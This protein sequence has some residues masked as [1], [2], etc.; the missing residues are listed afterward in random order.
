MRSPREETNTNTESESLNKEANESESKIATRDSERDTKTYIDS[1]R[2]NG[3]ERTIES[4]AYKKVANKTR[5]IATTLP[6]EFRIVRRIPSD[7]LVNLPILPTHPPEFEPGERYT[8]ERMEAMPVNKDGFLWPEEVKL[9]HYLIREHK[10]AFAWNENEKGKFSD[11]YFDPVV[12]PTVEHVPWVLRNIPIPPGIY[13]RVVEVIKHKIRTG[14]FESSNSSYRSRWFC[15][16][17]KDGKSLR[18]VHDLQPLNAVTIRDSALIPMVEQYAESFGGRGCYAMFDLFVGFDQRAL[19]IK[20]RDLTTFQ[21]P[22]GTFRMTSIPMGYT[23]SVQIQQG[24]I[25]FI[26]QEEIPH[27]T[28]P[29]IDDIP[30]KGPPTRYTDESGNFET[31]P[32][33]RGIRRFIWEHLQNV[34]RVIQRI[35]HAGGTFSG[36]KSFICVESTIIVGHRCTYEGRIPDESR[37]QKIMDWPICRNLT[38]VRG[39]LG[40]LGTIR[41]FIKNFAMH[42]RP[43]V[44][45]TRKNIEFEFGGEQLLAMEKMKFLTQE[46]PAIRTIDY[47]SENEVI[48]SVDSSWMAVGFILSQ[49]GDNGKRYPSRFGSIMWNEREQNYSQ[50]KIELYGL[51]RALKAVKLFIVGVKNLTVEVDAK[52]IKGMINNPDIQPS[53]TINRWIAGILL[54]HFKLRHVPGKD[55][56]SA[57]GLSRRP[58][59]PEDPVEDDD[60]EDW[61]DKSYAFG[62]ELLNWTQSS[63]NSGEEQP[64]TEKTYRHHQYY[65]SNRLDEW[66]TIFVGSLTQDQVE[67]P[68][69]DR[70]KARDDEIIQIRKF[71]EDPDKISRPNDKEFKRFIQSATKFFVNKNQLWRKDHHGKHKLVIPNDRRLDLIRQAHDDLGHKGIFT[72][73]NRLLERFW[74]PNLDQDVKWYIQT[75][76]ECQLRLLHKLIIPPTVPIPGGLFRKVYIDT[77]L[78]PKAK[79]Y[80]YIIHARCSLTSYPE[81]KMVKHE[82]FKTIAAFLYE[83]VCRWGAIEILV[84][85][86]APQYLQAAELL[87]EKFHIKH[88]KISPYNSRA[89]G[90][91]ERRHYDVREAI[92]K[93]AEGDESKWPDVAP[94]VFWAERVTIQKSTGYSPYYLAHGVEPLLPFDLAEG[95]YLAPDIN[96]SMSTE[97]LIALRAKMLLKRPQD[98]ARVRE[99]V[100]KARWESVKQLEKDLG[101]RIKE[102]KFQPGH[103]VLVRNSRFDKGLANKTKPRFL[104]P[105]VVIRKTRGGSYIL[106]EL[107]GALSK[108]RFAAFRLIPYLP[109]DIRSIP[110]TRL[111]DIPQEELEDLTHDSG[112]A[113]DVDFDAEDNI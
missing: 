91:I 49:I 36:L 21:T 28:V 10:Y 44:Q 6:E 106:G 87:A 9:V 2:T 105:M 24:D 31:I 95:T 61:I 98:L 47:R 90:P 20:S 3:T 72:V 93:A 4:L 75:C 76:H 110:V 102:F 12:I 45:L 34:N 50:A 74:W 79:G 89:Q 53:A 107:D 77:M 51:F 92:M 41:V 88:I 33:N 14:V 99:R 63:R 17:K 97:D 42:A 78:M 15:V 69:S 19:D 13:D 80:R 59:A 11:E 65:D 22:L 57:D 84:T 1:L 23:N 39:F 60:H 68:R 109:R 100:L 104:G 62:V 101:H 29:F 86:N 64:R 103:L 112:N 111:A 35:K 26:L 108:L 67:I 46:C 37:V 18:L 7:P 55:H 5:P 85:D 81:W 54:F 58:Q 16:L 48:L 25:T 82:N 83:L 27:V 70:A 94:A 66:P 71:L 73:R 8:R 43:L 40:T 52:Y 32:E 38:E 96:G 30:V 113:L 56:A